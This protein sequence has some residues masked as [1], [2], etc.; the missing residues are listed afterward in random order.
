MPLLCGK[1]FASLLITAVAGS[2]ALTLGTI[3]AFVDAA[4]QKAQRDRT[5][6]A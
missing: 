1:L 4:D 3:L 2:I 6:S 5:T